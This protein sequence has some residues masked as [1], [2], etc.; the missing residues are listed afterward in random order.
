MSN[1]HFFK[2]E[3]LFHGEV[4]FAALVHAC[5]IANGSLPATLLPMNGEVLASAVPREASIQPAAK[6]PVRIAPAPALRFTP[7]GA[8]RFASIALPGITGN[9]LVDRAPPV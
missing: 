6:K 2:C 1:P 9:G 8:M 3:E 7:C 5:Q 4:F